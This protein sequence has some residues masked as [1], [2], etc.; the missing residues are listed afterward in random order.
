MPELFPDMLQVWTHKGIS[1]GWLPARA[2]AGRAGS[3]QMGISEQ[4]P[5]AALGGR[6][7]LFLAL[8]S[9]Q[10]Q[11]HL[12][13][14]RALPFFQSLEIP[15]M[16]SW[17]MGGCDMLSTELVFLLGLPLQSF[18]LVIIRIITF[19]IFKPLLVLC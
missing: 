11:G 7:T 4:Q 18:S 1:A 12:L 8:P 6:W 10:G 15:A 17:V 19:F 5:R 14:T 9:L 2:S 13:P 16:K 3:T